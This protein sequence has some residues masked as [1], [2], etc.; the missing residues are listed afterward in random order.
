VPEQSFS[1]LRI[2]DRRDQDRVLSDI[3]CVSE[4][5]PRHRLIGGRHEPSRAL[6]L[7]SAEGAQRWAGRFPERPSEYMTDNGARP[8]R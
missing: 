7:P 6:P 1:G 2:L 3:G 5:D 4:A 8:H